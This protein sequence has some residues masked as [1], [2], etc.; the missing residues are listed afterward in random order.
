M[1]KNVEPTLK[2]SKL[3]LISLN[4]LQPSL[5]DIQQKCLNKSG[6]DPT[7]SQPTPQNLR[8]HARHRNN[9]FPPEPPITTDNRQQP[10]ISTPHNIAFVMQS[11]IIIK[12]NSR[13][14]LEED[15]K[16]PKR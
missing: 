3:S 11:A 7:N 15:N 2:I 12:I 4:H 6:H 8:L 5:T 16:Y 13:S 14:E 9:K 1:L 10:A